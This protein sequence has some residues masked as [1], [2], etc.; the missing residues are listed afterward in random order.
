MPSTSTIWPTKGGGFTHP[1]DLSDL[2]DS[3]AAAV[4]PRLP[5][6]GRCNGPATTGGTMW[7]SDAG[8]RRPGGGIRMRSSAKGLVRH[9]ILAAALGPL[10]VLTFAAAAGAAPSSTDHRP[11]VLTTGLQGSVGSAV[12]PDGALYVTEALAGRVSRVDR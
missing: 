1:V 12:G 3:L 11:Q 5:A 2:I 6:R 4:P 8:V 10:M 9:A 7:P